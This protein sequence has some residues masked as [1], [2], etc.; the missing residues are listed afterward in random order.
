MSYSLSVET[1]STYGHPPENGDYVAAAKERHA[2]L[3][4][5]G[6]RAERLYGP[7]FV[8]VKYT[9]PLTGDHHT[10]TYTDAENQT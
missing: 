3:R 4:I 8:Q 1:V 5:S 6:V 2:R 9:D 10:L 7:G